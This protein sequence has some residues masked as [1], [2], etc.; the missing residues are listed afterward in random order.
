MSLKHGILSHPQKYIINF[1]TFLKFQ[2][3][4]VYFEVETTVL[5]DFDI[6]PAY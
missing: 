2:I 5:W 4:F 1:L 6:D 3:S